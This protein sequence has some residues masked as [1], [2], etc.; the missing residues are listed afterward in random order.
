MMSAD[1]D[2]TFGAPRRTPSSPGGRGLDLLRSGLERIQ[3]YAVIGLLLGGAVMLA[4]AAFTESSGTNVPVLST[5]ATAP[6]PEA[7]LPVSMRKAPAATPG[8][9]LS[10]KRGD[11]ADAL[12]VDCGSPHL[13]EQA[14]PVQ[15]TQFGPGTSLP[16]DANFRTLVNQ[17][18][19]PLV[20]NYLHGAYDPDG[21]Y[22]AGA[23]KPSE[24]SWSDGDR[25]MRCGLQRFSRSGALYPITGKV[26]GHDQSDVHAPGTCLGIDG[27]FI[28]DPVECS[29]PHAVESVGFVDL[30]QKFSKGYP[31]VSDQDGVLQPACTK[32]ASD[33]AGGQQKLSDENLSVMWDNVTERSWNAG[34][35]KA[36]CSLAAQLPDKS[37]F[38]PITGDVRGDV[39][40]GNQPAP[41]AAA[42]AAAGSPADGGPTS[43]ADQ[44]P[45]NG[46]DVSTPDA[47]PDR[48]NGPPNLGD[49]LGGN[50]DNRDKEKPGENPLGGN[51]H[52][53]LGG[54]GHNPLGGNNENP[55]GGN[56]HNPLGGNGH[57]P[58]GG[59]GHNP[60]GG[61][62]QNPLGGGGQSPL[63]GGGN[64]LGG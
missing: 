60:L 48:R 28:G 39:K 56:G 50:R 62:G 4:T 59:N 20:A 51:G 34:S 47:A 61:D 26:A 8:T 18:C 42:R 35:R 3:L 10:W 29:S 30:T 5:L 14:G 45:A 7:D 21:R 41:P 49:L 54:N 64:P 40:V 31:K 43:D 12:M 44:G 22:R 24:K 13:F 53:P 2:P 19:A 6:V 9:C 17:L 25:S 32:L 52:N 33:F 23:L 15:L 16:S 1:M 36:S 38:A 57:N 55:L 27:K 11:A 58:L 63:G 37:G 46:G